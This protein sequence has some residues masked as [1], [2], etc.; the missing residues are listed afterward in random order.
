MAELTKRDGGVLHYEVRGSAD[1]PTL[2]LIEGLSAHMLGWREEFMRF[3]LDAGYRVVRFDNRDVGLSQRYP[4]RSYGLFDLAEDTHELIE[5]LGSTPV[6]VVGQSMGGMVAQNLAVLFPD[7][8]ASLALLYTTA[9]SVHIDT[10]ARGP[11]SPGVERR[12]ATRDEAIQL[13]IVQERLC[14]SRTYSFDEEWKRELGGLMWD[15]GYDPD[16][17]ARQTQ[18]VFAHSIESS[19]LSSIGVPTLLIHGTADRLIDYD[20][21]VELYAAIPGSELWLVEGMG[22]DLPRELWP[23]LTNLIVA[24]AAKA[25]TAVAAEEQS[26]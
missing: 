26:A 25:R 19:R 20:A 11:H 24:N 16:G 6:H 4:G 5:H 18:A 22:H 8:V 23:S 1:S 12:A 2:L 10:G 14:A 7:D 17:V 21:S 15:R 9:T 13:H 3:F